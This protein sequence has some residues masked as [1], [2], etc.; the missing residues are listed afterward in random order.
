MNCDFH[1]KYKKKE[2]VNKPIL[3]GLFA[4][5]LLIS[6][7]III[8]TLVNS[9]EHA[10]EQFK[11]LWYLMIPLIIGFG[12][13][14][15]L[16]VY[17]RSASKINNISNST[18]ATAGGISTTSMI[19]CCAHHLTD[20]IPILGLSAATLFLSKYQTL[21][22]TIGIISNII[23]LNL[24]LKIIQEHHLYN[25]NQKVISKIMQINMK[26]AFLIISLFSTIIFLIILFKIV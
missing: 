12:L 14:I 4:S 9:F 16:F 2:L 23:G 15:S 10:I 11:E 20:I 22:L 19:A 13:Q 17:I 21:F 24:M 6:I 26:K 18:I 8:L 1:Q 5:F 3:W 7:Y 25:Q